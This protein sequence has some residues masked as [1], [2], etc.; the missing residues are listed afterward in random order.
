MGAMTAVPGSVIAGLTPTAL[1]RLTTDALGTGRPVPDLILGPQA[2]I[3]VRDSTAR[4]ATGSDGAFL[5]ARAYLDGDS[6]IEVTPAA[7]VC[8][9]HLMLERHSTV[10]AAGVEV[11]T[12][13]PGPG[14]AAAFGPQSSGL[15]LSMFPHLEGFA[16]FGPLAGPRL[17]AEDYTALRAG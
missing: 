15:F 4:L 14:A 3:L 7:P 5:P 13:H 12:Y 6:V 11:E 1:T 9:Y 16:Q 2:R 8:V 17:S 10:R